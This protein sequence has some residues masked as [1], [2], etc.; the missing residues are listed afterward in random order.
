[1][2]RARARQLP[3]ALVSSKGRVKTSSFSSLSYDY[4]VI[5][6]GI[7]GVNVAQVL[8]L[9]RPLAKILILDKENA[10]GLHGSGR[11][12]G[13]LHAGFYYHADSLKAKLTAQGNAY[14]R[15]YITRK[16]L[17]MNKCGKLVVA[18]NEA[19]LSGLDELLKRGKVNGVQVEEVDEA[20]S[21]RIEPF[22]KTHKRALWS[23]TTSVSDPRMVLKAQI[24]DVIQS[25]VEVLFGE[26]VRDVQLGV[27]E[28]GGRGGGISKVTTEGGKV[29]ESGC[30]INCAGLYADV[31]GKMMGHGK[32]L[33]MLP[34]KG[35]YLYCNV[36]LKR[37]VYP[38]P[39]LGQPFL[40]VHFTVRS[41]G[42][43][44]CK[45]GPTAI[46]AFWREHYNDSGSG[47]FSN[48]KSLE[49]MEVLSIEARLFAAQEKLRSLAFTEMAK[50]SKKEM[51]RGA[52]E[53]VPSATLE[54]FSSYGKAGIR[55]QLVDCSSGMMSPSK[56]KLV[57][58][59]LMQGSGEEGGVSVLNAISPAWT[60]S[61]PVAELVVDKVLM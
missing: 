9:R 22:A 32:G 52:A 2:F 38:V 39:D 10:A 56:W 1:M 4:V 44:G 51:A 23:P 11:N 5:G 21:Q 33:H 34:F 26:G 45:I 19:D 36:K 14:L 50:Y 57:M 12:S 41:D 55:A 6:A 43:E 61:R 48:F 8:K 42:E 7:I 3:S 35:L 60:C 28:G 53:L 30:V 46:P 17:P 37:L 29:I 31:I 20:Q 40:G 24:E 16:G 47:L 58:D 27:G 18:K 49:A 54:T 13:V 59:F 15:S 25:G